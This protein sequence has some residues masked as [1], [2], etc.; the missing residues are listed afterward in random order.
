MAEKYNPDL[1]R[2]ILEADELTPVHSRWCLLCEA[3]L[4]SDETCQN[5]D[6]PYQQ[7]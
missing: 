2:E 6:C 7:I 4:D 5:I 3:W 1:V